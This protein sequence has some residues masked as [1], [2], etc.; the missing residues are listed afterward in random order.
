MAKSEPDPVPRGPQGGR[1]HKPGR[2]HDRKSGRRKQ[3]RFR[4]KAAAQAA[5]Q[6]R[7][8]R[9]QWELWDRLSPT[10]KKYR[11]DLEP[12]LPRPDDENQTP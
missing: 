6:L 4:R 5:E 3:Q 1:K 10:A 12:T 9:R 7:E 11:P 8:A 2:G